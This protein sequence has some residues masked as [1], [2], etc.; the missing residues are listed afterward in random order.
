MML[1]RSNKVNIL[2]AL[3]QIERLET[4]IAGKAGY[5]YPP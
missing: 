1:F 3:D 4:G 2:K 5:F